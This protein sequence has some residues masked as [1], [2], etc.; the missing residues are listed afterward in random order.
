MKR[1][2]A[3]VP[4]AVVLLIV[5]AFAAFPQEETK[6]DLLLKGGRVIDPANQVNQV[7]DVAVRDGKI[8]RVDRNIPAGEAAKVISAKGYYV[9][10]GIIDI[11]AHV[12]YTYFTSAARSVIPDDICFPSG[13]TTVVDAGTSGADNVE[14]FLSLLGKGRSNT[15]VRT[16]AFL[17]ISR[18]GMND[19]EQDP[20]N[21]DVPAAVAMARKHP[22]FIVGFKTAHYWTNAPYDELHT[23]WATVDSLLAAGRAANLPVMIDF[24]PR[25]EEGT[26]PSRSYRELILEKM[27]PGDI[28]THNFARHIPVIREDGTVNPDILEAQKRGV[29]FDLGHGA[30]SFVY[31]NAV[32]AMKQGYIPNSISTDLHGANTPGPVINMLFVMTKM[33]NLGMPLEDV[34]RR[35]TIIPAREI[36]HPELGSLSVGGPADIAMIEMRKGRF[37]FPDTSAGKVT[38]NRK[39]DCVLTVSQGR[40]VWDPNGWTRPEWEKIPRDAEYWKNPSASKY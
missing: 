40:V 7:M 3:V 19:G 18:T 10:P 4:V 29:I 15:R 26:W 6:Y 22:G 34:I 36:N 37:G 28:H 35:S 23:P 20:R 12:Y 27:R 13:V 32:P 8:A 5:G 39:L 30:G 16:F 25:S 1:F 9:T 2:R 14:D 21:F 38:G 11:H 31:R 17:N 24:F 33:L